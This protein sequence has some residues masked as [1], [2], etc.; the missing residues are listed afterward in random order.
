[1]SGLVSKRLFDLLPSRMPPGIKL[2]LAEN[3]WR[4]FGPTSRIDYSVGPDADPSQVI[5]S[6]RAK[7]AVAIQDY[8]IPENVSNRFNWVS[9]GD[10]RAKEALLNHFRHEESRVAMETLDL[11]LPALLAQMREHGQVTGAATTKVDIQRIAVSLCVDPSLGGSFREGRPAP[12]PTPARGGGSGA[13]WL[14]IA[15][16]VGVL[17]MV[18]MSH[19]H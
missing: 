1:M 6:V 15:A 12:K 3:V 11:T 2:Q 14:I 19:R 9:G 18:L 7:V 4:H 10:V 17:I 13:V 16:V 8:R 5:S